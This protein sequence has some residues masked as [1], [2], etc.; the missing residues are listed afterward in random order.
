MNTEKPFGEVI[1]AYTRAQAI[2]DGVLVDLSQFELIRRAWKFPFACTCAVWNAIE[3]GIRV[4][5]NDVNGILHDITLLAQIG[6]KLGPNGDII[7]IDVLIG[8]KCERLKLHIGPGDTPEP[9]LTLMME[10]ED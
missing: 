2:Q 10:N 6:I 1:F 8:G 9:V 5:G 4:D 7:R 3:S